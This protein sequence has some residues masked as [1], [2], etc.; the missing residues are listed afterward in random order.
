[1]PQ[2]LCQNCGVRN[3]VPAGSTHFICQNCGQR[4]DLQTIAETANEALL[5]DMVL[6]PEAEKELDT[7]SLFNR[8]AAFE[9]VH[10]YEEDTSEIKA[11]EDAPRKDSIYYTA[12][13]KMSG[14]DPRKYE[15]AMRMLQALGAWKDAP[16]L[17]EECKA[18]ITAIE[19]R[20]Q[21]QKAEARR[22]SKQRKLRLGIGIP[23]TVAALAAVILTIFVFV[24]NSR[25]KQA[26][27]AQS[28]GDTK[29]AYELFADLGSY[30]DSAQRAKALFVQY[31]ENALINAKKGDIVYFGSYP[32]D[33]SGNARDIS[34]RVLNKEDDTLFLLSEYGLDCKRFH[35]ENASVTWASCSLRKWLNGDFLEAA[36]SPDQ[37]Q[38]IVE[39]TVTAEKNADY[40]TDPGI[41]TVDK[42][43]LLSIDEAEF[44]LSDDEQK[45][46]FPTE[47]SFLQGTSSG[48]NKYNGN[49]T[50]SWFLRTPGLDNTMAS[51]VSSAG[52]IR[53][54]GYAVNTDFIT[55]RPAIRVR[56]ASNSENK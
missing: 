20:A 48:N 35:E 47:Y 1:M 41:D 19:Q 37:Q 25:Y 55:L 56:I 28:S 4:Q 23:A 17:V 30:K 50:S 45:R 39:S 9:N 14:D 32:Q 18:Q 54:M 16:A 10:I 40:D 38:Q 27:A 8:F 36:F 12:L 49:Y 52:K 43:F 15:E 34:W 6:E 53:H 33:S 26:L 7:S 11:Q 13:S 44:Y 24:P 2:Y 22:T 42:V 51:Y 21:Q 3:R 31:K 46:C 29:T 5:N